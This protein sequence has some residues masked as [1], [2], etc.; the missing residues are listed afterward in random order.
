MAKL[1]EKALLEVYKAILGEEQFFTVLFENRMSFYTGLLSTIMTAIVL[2]IYYSKTLIEFSAL[3]FGPIVL[4]FV[5]FSGINAAKRGTTRVY[6]ILA[7]RAKLEQALDLTKPQK[8]SGTDPNIYWNLEPL[9]DVEHISIRKSYKT[10]AEFSEGGVKNKRNLLH[11]TIRFYGFFVILGII[12]EV[13][14]AARIF[15]LF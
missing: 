7:I 3:A 1:T 14:I 4:I 6:K 13:F 2:G 8:Y 10:S 15:L 9:A 12:S 11:Q 5:S